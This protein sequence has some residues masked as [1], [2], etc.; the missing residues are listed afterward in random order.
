MAIPFLLEETTEQS[1]ASLITAEIHEGKTIEYKREIAL[2]SSDQKRKFVRSVASFANASGGEMIFGMEAIDGKASQIRPL[3]DFDPDAGV[4]LL[5]DLVR[6]HVQPPL[7]GTEFKPVP[8]QNGW[9]LVM[10]VGRSWKPPHMVTFD[11]DNRFYTRDANGCVPM[12]ISEIR[13]AF[14]ASGTVKE[15]IQEYRFQRLSAIRSGEH[16]LKL[17]KLP[18]SVLHILPFRSFVEDSEVNMNALAQED[19]Y[20]PSNWRSF[21]PTYDMD[22]TY[23][24]GWDGDREC[25]NYTFVSRSGCIE[26]LTNAGLPARQDW[27]YISNPGFEKQFFKIIPKYFNLLRK[28]NVEPP[29]V[30]ALTLL[31][32]SGFCLY[33]GPMTSLSAHGVRPIRQRDLSL[34][35]ITVSS[36]DQPVEEMLRPIF[37]ALWN[38]CGLKRSFNYN[39]DGSWLDRTWD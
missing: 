27:K 36:F 28:L 25:G 19:L 8:V 30:V 35:A 4:R 26:G 15:R 11:G 24:C 3:A 9:A 34:P 10:R 37:D 13:E 5:R 16:P 22:G 29:V 33:S 2:N 7:F 21:G 12:N 6:A 18:F 38:S 39:Q 20:P 32:V 23:G 1:L 31:D 17:P 14:L